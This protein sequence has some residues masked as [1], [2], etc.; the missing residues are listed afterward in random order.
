MRLRQPLLLTALCA[1][2][3]ACGDSAT[4]PRYPDVAGS[5]SGPVTFMIDGQLADVGT[6]N[7]RVVQ[8]SDQIT[9]TSWS[10][11]TLDGTFQ[12]PAVTGTINETGF[13]TAT[14][15]GGPSTV[16]DPACG[17]ITAISSTLTFSGNTARFHATL[18]TDYCGNWALDATLAR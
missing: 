1:V 8:E 10:I 15:G 6:M 5:Y 3:L 13:F 12:L 4:E 9:L 16:S 11:T 18:V 7:L 2:T 17:N 14:A